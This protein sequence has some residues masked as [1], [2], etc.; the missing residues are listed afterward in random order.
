MRSEGI[1]SEGKLILIVGPSGAGKDTLMEQA[2]TYSSALQG[3]TVARRIITRPSTAGGEAHIEASEVEFEQACQ[4]G[5]YFAFWHAHNLKYALQK[6]IATLVSSGKIVLANVSRR[7]IKPIVDSG[8]P[9]SI[10]EVTASD[11]VRAE[12]IFKRGRESLE[13]IKKRIT[14][15]EW[16]VPQGVIKYV[17]DNSESLEQ[18]VNNFIIALSKA[19]GGSDTVTRLPIDMGNSLA[20][21][22]STNSSLYTQGTPP[23]RLE[24]RYFGKRISLRVLWDESDR[25]V[26][27]KT[28]GLPEFTLNSL[29]II[30]HAKVNLSVSNEPKS[31][32]Y[33]QKKISGTAA[34]EDE[35]SAIVLDIANNSYDESSVAAFITSLSYGLSDEELVALT[36]ARR[37]TAHS[38]TLDYP[39]LVDKHSMGGIPGNRITPL[40]IAIVAAHGLK[41][42]KA[43]SRAITSA[44]GTADT[45]A[46]FAEVDLS[47]QH[48]KKVIEETNGCLV[49]NGRISHTPFDDIANAI[50]RPLNLKSDRMSIASILS[51]KMA[52]GVTHLLVD[53]PVG[54]DTKIK[55]QTHAQSFCSAMEQTAKHIGMHVHVNISDGTQPVGCGVGPYLEACDI[56]QVLHNAPEAPQDLKEKALDYAGIIIQWDPKVLPGEGRIIAEDLL[57][58]GLAAQQFE[59]II[60]AQGKKEFPLKPA[61]YNHIIKSSHTGYIRNI[62]VWRINEI[63]RKAGA[64]KDILA[65]L[66]IFCKKGSYISKGDP[67]YKIHTSSAILLDSTI[68]M[69]MKDT[70]IS[71]EE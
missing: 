33:L 32:T 11:S 20:C 48:V 27:D 51:K 53:L 19:C 70:G 65:G 52:A 36:K 26:T 50:I 44:A 30:E 71:I 67:I 62:N 43:S 57:T 38:L 17:V 16:D 40:V 31:L 49:W 22:V 66:N 1:V 69:A 18:G 8:L 47:P 63:A 45:M 14:H 39:F 5:E 21:L 56:L 7:A 58:R 68:Q 59:K 55:D 60:E 6:N 41:I 4:N 9:I 37:K 64:P 12:R 10:I 23:T 15:V 35:Y 34:D 29:G 13:D 3:I 61:Q 46:V 28:V 24:M 54:R 25:L 42:P 2:L